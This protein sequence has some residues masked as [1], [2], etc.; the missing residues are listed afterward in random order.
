MNTKEKIQLIK[1]NI[2]EEK[3]SWGV[4]YKTEAWDEYGSYTCVY[5]P[6]NWEAMR[7]ILDW[8]EESKERKKSNDLLNSAIHECHK[9]DKEKGILTGNR[10]GL[11]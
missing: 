4:T 2:T 8:W 1:Y 5:E 3:R 6:T 7:Y 10:D 11:D 9:I